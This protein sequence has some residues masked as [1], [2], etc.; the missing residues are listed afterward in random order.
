[1]K[2]CLFKVGHMDNPLNVEWSTTLLSGKSR[3]RSSVILFPFKKELLARHL[4]RCGNG[5]IYVP[6]PPQR[7]L[8]EAEEKWEGKPNV[9]KRLTG[10]WPERVPLSKLMP[11]ITGL[12]RIWACFLSSFQRR[13]A[14]CALIKKDNVQNLQEKPSSNRQHQMAELG[15]KNTAMSSQR[16]HRACPTA[17]RFTACAKQMIAIF[18]PGES[19]GFSK[20]WIYVNVFWNC[21]DNKTKQNIWVK[22]YCYYNQ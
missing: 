22:E 1:M 11:G 7:H 2:G 5:L 4:Q 14:L 21:R 20:K 17:T 12:T 6:L 15:D 16:N 13:M 8:S 18:T 3:Y 19:L 9:C 10:I